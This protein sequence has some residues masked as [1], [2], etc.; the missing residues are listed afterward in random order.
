MTLINK[1]INI[2]SETKN[3]PEVAHFKGN[4]LYSKNLDQFSPQQ[5]LI[6]CQII[7]KALISTLKENC[8]IK[9]KLELTC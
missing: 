4:I 6:V 7:L 9:M 8:E 3:E 5:Q 1:I 2:I